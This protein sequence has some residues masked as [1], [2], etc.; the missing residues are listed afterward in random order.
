MPS[1]LEKSSTYGE[2]ISQALSGQRAERARG[3]LPDTLPVV[4]RSAVHAQVSKGRFR[5]PWSKRIVLVKWVIAGQAA[6]RI[7]GRRIPFGPGGVGSYVATLPLELR[8]TEHVSAM[9]WFSCDGPLAEQFVHLL[10]LR[11]GVF[12][13]GPAP[14]VQLGELIDSLK[15]QTL[16][17]RRQSSLLAIRMLYEVVKKLP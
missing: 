2:V 16:D 8:N 7:N 15:D 5:P 1:I 4:L 10:G 14:I 17:G 11:P 3:E 13:Y 6:I 9:C 12:H